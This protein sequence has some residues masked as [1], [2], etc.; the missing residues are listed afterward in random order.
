LNWIKC[1]TDGASN[2]NPGIASCGGIFR[3]HNANFVYAFAEPLGREIAF[4]AEL[5]GALKAIE[6]AFE[7]N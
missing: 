7:K 5:C 1:N 6:L 3:D 4:F 2:G